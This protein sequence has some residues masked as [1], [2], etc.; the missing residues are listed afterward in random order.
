MP[1]RRHPPPRFDLSALCWDR[2][3]RDRLA[4]LALGLAVGT[5]GG[6][7]AY[8]LNA[9]LA[10]MLG[11]LFGTMA[12][13]IAGWPV[14]G[15]MRLR[16]AFLIVIGL[17]LGQSFNAELLARMAAWPFS[18]ALAIL[19]IPA[20]AW[21][22][23]LYYRRVAGMNRADALFSC[24]PGGLSGVVLIAGALGA[25]ERRVALAQSL[26][27]AFVVAAA[28]AVF[29]GLLGYEAPEVAAHAPEIVSWGSAA[30]LAL[31]AAAGVAAL[32]A[33]GAPLPFLL[34]PMAASAVL[35]LGGWVEGELPHWMVEGALIVVGSSIGVR[36]AGVALSEFRRI[37]AATLVATVIMILVSGLF[38]LLSMLILGVPAAPAMLAYAPGGVAEMAL[39]AIAIDAD[40][41]FVAT[42]HLA[43]ISFILLLAPFAGAW[44]TRRWAAGSG[45]GSGGRGPSGDRGAGG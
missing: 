29:F 8:A 1:F 41:G 21:L 25:D 34:G 10:F 40:P 13:S 43:R 12:A 31:A 27:V 24:V 6:F 18:I 30:A 26:R 32:A 42:H 14:A 38:S 4:R 28:P 17:F 45:G 16:S 5:V 44:F 7:V 22:A 36:F 3:D 9:P 2:L 11:S 19:Y 15:S 23:F 37:A 39:I 20:A 35:R 33:I